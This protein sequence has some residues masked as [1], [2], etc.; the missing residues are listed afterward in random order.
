MAFVKID[1][2]TGSIELI[3]FPSVYTKTKSLWV[4]DRIILVKGKV[5]EKEE[6]MNII[7]DDAKLLEV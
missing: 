1:D 6:R 7:V 2:F 5:G 4:T 3:V